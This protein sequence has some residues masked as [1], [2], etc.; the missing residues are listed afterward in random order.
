MD[1][2]Y[3]SIPF[4]HPERHTGTG[5]TYKLH[6]ERWN[7]SLLVMRWQGTVDQYQWL[8]HSW[9]LK[10]AFILVMMALSSATW[11]QYPFASSAYWCSCLQ[12]DSNLR[13]LSH[14]FLLCRINAI[15]SSCLR[16]T[17]QSSSPAN[18]KVGGS[19]PGC[20]SLHAKVSLGKILNLKL[21]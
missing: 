13:L 5:R 8:L 16:L 14:P 19:I 1:G 20:S 3:A 9:T 17:R 2:F 21:L 18:W 10:C 7:R 11:L 6:A 4:I 12:S 15:Y